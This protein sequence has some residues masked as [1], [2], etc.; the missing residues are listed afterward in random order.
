MG[1]LMGILHF[2]SNGAGCGDFGGLRGCGAVRGLR[3]LG[4]RG[5][6]VR[7]LGLAVK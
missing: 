2:S 7:I 6:T 5:S 3:E 4:S 1:L